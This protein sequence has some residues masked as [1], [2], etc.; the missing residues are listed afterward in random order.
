MERKGVFRATSYDDEQ[1]CSFSYITESKCSSK[2]A[3]EDYFYNHPHETIT[4]TKMVD[5][6][7]NEYFDLLQ[8]GGPTVLGSNPPEVFPADFVS[9]QA[10]FP[11]PCDP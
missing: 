9:L 3:A 4:D 7:G 10:V 2:E 11:E 8:A 6:D 5:V 1:L